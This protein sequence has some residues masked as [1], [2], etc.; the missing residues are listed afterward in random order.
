MLSVSTDLFQNFLVTLLKST[1][2][3]HNVQ[4]KIFTIR[5]SNPGARK[6]RIKFALVAKSLS[7][8]FSNAL[9]I[10]IE[11][12]RMGRYSSK[13]TAQ[14]KSDCKRW[15][16]GVHILY[17][18]LGVQMRCAYHLRKVND[19]WFARVSSYENI[20]LV[21]VAMNEPG[22]GESDDEVH[23]FRIQFAR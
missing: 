17:L 21:E 19:D 12:P 13:S 23:Q 9:D 5:L 4:P 6:S 1:S 22:P 10:T 8:E 11:I 3:H 18:R 15:A 16:Q 7:E 2:G 14:R 20:E